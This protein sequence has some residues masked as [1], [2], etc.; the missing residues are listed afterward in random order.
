MKINTQNGFIFKKCYLFD[1]ERC[2]FN[3]LK[4]SNYDISNLGT[5]KDE[6]NINIGILMRD[7][8]E[9]T[10]FLR[11]KTEEIINYYIEKNNLHSEDIILRQYDGIITT[12]FLDHTTGGFLDLPIRKTFSI[13]ISSIDG[14][15]YISKYTTDNI[16]DYSFKGIA[17]IKKYKKMQEVY[18]EIC[19]INFNNL[20]EIFEKLHDIQNGFINSEDPML[21]AIPNS[22][23]SKPFSIILKKYGRLNVSFSTLNMLDVSDVDTHWYWKNY[24]ER[25]TKSITLTFVR[26]YTY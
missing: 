7:N 14:K 1:I 8:P 18:K 13:F 2:H 24:I 19:N 20:V 9:L 10:E 5:E 3:L 23:R 22:D 4:K 16:R 25:F 11:G 21:F 12:K 6:I 17:G 15:Y 26:N